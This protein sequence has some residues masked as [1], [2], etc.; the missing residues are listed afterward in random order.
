MNLM[1]VHVTL[2]VDTV[3]YCYSVCLSLSLLVIMDPQDK[4]AKQVVN[5]CYCNLQSIEMH[6]GEKAED[7]INDKP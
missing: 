2:K 5:Y 6:A 3:P 7:V 1:L 4:S